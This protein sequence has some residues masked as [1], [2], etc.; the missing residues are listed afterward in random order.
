VKRFLNEEQIR[1]YDRTWRER[2]PPLDTF[3]VASMA[4]DAGISPP[5]LQNKFAANDPAVAFVER[6]EYGYYGSCVSSMRAYGEMLRRNDRRQFDHTCW[7]ASV[8]A[9]VGAKTA[10]Q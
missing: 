3:C 10:A 7:S 1:E 5:T 6:L 2:F 8:T 4:H 9:D